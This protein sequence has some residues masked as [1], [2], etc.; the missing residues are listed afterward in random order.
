VLPIKALGTLFLNKKNTFL[1]KM[2]FH[3]F[4]KNAKTLCREP[5]RGTQQRFFYKKYSLPSATDPAL[6]K[7]YFYF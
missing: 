6:G 4:Q 7:G 5:G 2:I 1:E 3:Y